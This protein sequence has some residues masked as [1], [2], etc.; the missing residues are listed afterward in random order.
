MSKITEQIKDELLNLP[1]ITQVGLSGVKNYELVIEISEKKLT[2]FGLQIDHISAAIKRGSI[3]LPGGKLLT[4]NGDILL[5]HKASI[6]R[7]A[8]VNYF[9]H[10]Y[11]MLTP[12]VTYYRVLNKD[13][14]NNNYLKYYFDGELFQKTIHLP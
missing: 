1:Q 12:Q 2:E 5:T 7:T 14:L 6:G 11:V 8:I 3:D 10:P 13:K 9:N 4:K